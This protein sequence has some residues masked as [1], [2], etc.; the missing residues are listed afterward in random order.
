MS[1]T[2][3]QFTIL[4]KISGVFLKPFNVLIFLLSVVGTLRK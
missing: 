1:P 4:N 3:V 2:F